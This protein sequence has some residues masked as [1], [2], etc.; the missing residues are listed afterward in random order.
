VFLVLLAL[1]LLGGC[2]VS[3]ICL[4]C[5][6]RDSGT[7]GNSESG[8][9]GIGGTGGTG[10]S[11]G[12]EDSGSDELDAS[13]DAGP[14]SSV[15]LSDSGRPQC[16]PEGPELCDNKDQDCD[17]R[18]DEQVVPAVNDCLQRGVCA[19]SAPVCAGGN[20][21][22]RYSNEYEA[23]ESLCDGKD[24]DCDGQVDET[25]DELGAECEVGVGACKVKGTRQCNTAGT[26][27]VCVIPGPKEPGAEICNGEDD[28]CD[29]MIDE[30]KSAPGSNPSYVID[31]VVQVRSDLWIYKHEASRTDAKFNA[32]GIVSRRACSRGGALPWTNVTYDEANAACAA[33]DMELCA[34]ADWISAC[35]G[36]SGSCR[37]SYTPAMGS[38]STYASGACNGTG[39]N[40]TLK[41]TNE[42]PLCY[43]DFG[44]A[45]KVYDL[46]G[47]AKEWTRGAG[48]PGS[49]SLRG[50]SYNQGDAALECEF[51]WSKAAPT[52]RLPNVGFRCCTNAAP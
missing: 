2:K 24:N 51:D 11:S 40:G 43:A 45:G 41:A 34:E 15:P 25:F 36:Q 37:W 29:G 21:I 12:E 13:D 18:V 50:G 1:L 48:S 16:E 26:G 35:K 30:P 4:S 8:S 7:A 32:P 39:D 20:F 6:E 22:C 38:C 28:D 27:L 3:P 23:T 5:D 14:D 17:L 33:A 42:S 47:N 31:E 52:L 49:N 9:G 19:G 10:G 46:S 44:G